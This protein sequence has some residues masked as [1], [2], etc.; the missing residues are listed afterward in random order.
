MTV[1]LSHIFLLSSHVA[2][3]SFYQILNLFLNGV[4]SFL[5]V[6]FGLH[7]YA[8]NLRRTR[9]PNIKIKAVKGALEGEKIVHGEPTIVVENLGPGNASPFIIESL[10]FTEEEVAFINWDTRESMNE[11][12]HDSEENKHLRAEELRSG[13][14]IE[15]KIPEKYGLISDLADSEEDSTGENLSATAHITFRAGRKQYGGAYNIKSARNGLR[16]RELVFEL[17][18]ADKSKSSS[19]KAWISRKF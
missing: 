4:T 9:D 1:D 16:H 13:E 6:Y 2:N 3:L 14:E 15:F 12:L 11:S 7:Q 17:I 10:I 19:L 8:T 18:P 5:L